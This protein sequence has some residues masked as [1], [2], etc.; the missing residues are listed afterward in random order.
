M[1]LTQTARRNGAAIGP[2][3][4]GCV[5]GTDV[6]VLIMDRHVVLTLDRAMLFP[7]FSLCAKLL[8][9]GWYGH[10]GGIN[11]IIIFEQKHKTSRAKSNSESS[12]Q[13]DYN[14]GYNCFIISIK[15]GV[16]LH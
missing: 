7:V 5:R 8:L 2:Q 13:S 14:P 9:T 3:Q 12:L 16:E 6:Y 4:T 10:K 1:T 15:Y 11:L